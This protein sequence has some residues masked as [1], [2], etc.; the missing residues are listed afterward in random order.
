MAGT[1]EGGRKAAETNKRKHGA[2]FYSRLGKV[3]GKHCSP[4]KGFGSM[5]KAKLK[6]ISIKAGKV[7][8][9]HK[10]STRRKHDTSNNI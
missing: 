10:H 6:A 4:S 9:L 8:G 2:D 3:G 1:I 7:G 5:D